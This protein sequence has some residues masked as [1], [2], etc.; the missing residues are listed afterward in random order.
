MSTERKPK[1]RAEFE[2]ES[3]DDLIKQML[4]YLEKQTLMHDWKM[5]FSLR[6]V[7]EEIADSPC[8]SLFGS[9]RQYMENGSD[10]LDIE[11]EHDMYH[12]TIHLVEKDDIGLVEFYVDAS[13]AERQKDILVEK[14][15][16][17]GHFFAIRTKPIEKEN[18][19]E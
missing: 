9:V 15:D 16:C 6:Y 14:D 7:N 13:C 5:N 4:E 18:P 10:W 12:I 11:F 8:L 1:V 2:A 17:A 3:H 19:S